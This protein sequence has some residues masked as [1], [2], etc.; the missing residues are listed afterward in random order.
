MGDAAVDVSSSGSCRSRSYSRDRS[1]SRSP[2]HGFSSTLPRCCEAVCRDAISIYY[3]SWCPLC[4]KQFKKSYTE[5]EEAAQFARRHLRDMHDGN[6]GRIIKQADLT[7]RYEDVQKAGSNSTGDCYFE[8]FCPNKCCG[9]VKRQKGIYDC[10]EAYRFLV[11]HMQGDY[12]KHPCLNNPD[13]MEALKTI[14]NEWIKKHDYTPPPPKKSHKE[15]PYGDNEWRATT[16]RQVHSEVYIGNI[17]IETTLENFQRA[18]LSSGLGS[19]R[20][21][22]DESWKVYAFATYTTEEDAQRAIQKI[23]VLEMHGRR[24]TAHTS[25]RYL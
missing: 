19:I 9:Q 24:L 14:P 6:N 8:V 17:P 4:Q 3:K 1:R 11:D 13:V 5:R 12:E 22:L 2:S 20:M 10:H 21:H 7:R 25:T 23:N 18:I 16:I 15:K